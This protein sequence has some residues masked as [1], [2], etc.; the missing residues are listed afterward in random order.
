MRV[1]WISL[2]LCA[3]K[4][5]FQDV[6]PSDDDAP[7]DSGPY[8]DVCGDASGLAPN[9]PWPLIHGCRTNAGRSAYLGPDNRATGLGPVPIDAGWTGIVVG[10]GH[11]AMFSVYNP[12]TTSAFDMVS[13]GK[14]WG[15][16]TPG[17]LPWLALGAHDDVYVPSD[18]GVFYCLDAISGAE[19]WQK[20]IAG[21][22]Q[23][24]MLAFDNV[25]FGSETYGIWAV[26]TITDMHDVMWHYDVPGGGRV[27]ALALTAGRIYFVDTLASRLYGLDAIT[28][29]HIFDVPI[30]GDA[31]GAP[32]IGIDAIYVATM[33][34]GIAAF[35]LDDGALKWQ[36]PPAA[37]PVVQPALLADG[38]VMTASVSGLASLINRKTGA[39]RGS[40]PIGGNV[41][42]P[43][44][45]AV[46]DTVYFSTSIGI[47]AFEP[48]TGALRWQSQMSG[49]MALGER[50]IVVVPV[51]GQFAVIGPS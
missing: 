50:A 27:G 14:A 3:C 34:S 23:A 48:R 1:W 40:F 46:D 19:R 25:Y 4:F 51:E 9:A 38:D 41:N 43:P 11:Q 13:G 7:A 49:Q 47:L 37:E 2:A 32:V 36:Q 44:I 6:A 5:G 24:P 35:E 30:A 18:H 45:F 16:P 22:L 8:V 26:E 10:A 39:V 33:T 42:A 28:G 29:E 15:T 21:S 17:S 12:G 31:I 20:Q